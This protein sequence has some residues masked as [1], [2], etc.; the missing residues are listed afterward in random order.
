MWKNPHF[1]IAEEALPHLLS[2]SCPQK[3][4]SLL[5]RMRGIP[6]VTQKIHPPLNSFKFTSPTN[7]DSYQTGPVSSLYQNSLVALDHVAAPTPMPNE[8]FASLSFWVL[9]LT[10]AGRALQLF[11]FRHACIASRPLTKPPNCQKLYEREMAGQRSLLQSTG[12]STPLSC[13]AS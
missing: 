5:L 4:P 8:P 11:S 9:P 12:G 6:G 7:A 13:A 3:L 1:E 10:K 2:I